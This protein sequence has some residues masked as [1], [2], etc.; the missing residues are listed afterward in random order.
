MKKTKKIVLFFHG[1]CISAQENPKTYPAKAVSWLARDKR[2]FI[3]QL[4]QNC[5]ESSTIIFDGPGA[6]DDNYSFTETIKSLMGIIDGN[7]GKSGIQSNLEKARNFIE[8]EAQKAE[9][10]VEFEIHAFGYSRGGFAVLLLKFV[11]QELL[12]KNIKI[13]AAYLTAFDPVPGGPIDRLRIPFNFYSCPETNIY[14]KIYYSHTGNLNIWDKTIQYFPTKYR[15]NMLFF[16]AFKD[17]TEINFAERYSNNTQ[18]YEHHSEAYIV[19]ANHE[20]IIGQYMN[21]IEEHAGYVTLAHVLATSPVSF[22]P[23]WKEN[24]ITQGITGSSKLKQLNV[25]CMPGRKFL[26]EKWFYCFIPRDITKKDNI[27]SILDINFSNLNPNQ[28]QNNN[29]EKI[30]CAI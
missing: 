8:E 4:H 27:N 22:N 16:S 3:L 9:E 25:S 30:S 5:E 24:A 26:E 2:N 6:I 12:Q 28:S 18:Q 20:G 23:L 29:V 11:I 10:D 15:L 7:I 1:T 19:P 21:E 14:V 13:K 17:N